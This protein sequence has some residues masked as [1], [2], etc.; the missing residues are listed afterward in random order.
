MVEKL[1]LNLDHL[2]L[3]FNEIQGFI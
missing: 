1:G 3:M 2:L